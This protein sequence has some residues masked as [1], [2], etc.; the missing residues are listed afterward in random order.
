M[1][2][3]LFVYG[4]LMAGIKTKV[5]REFHQN[6]TFLGEGYLKGKMYDLGH[7]PGVVYDETSEQK[8]FGHVF[9]LKEPEKMLKKLDEYEDVGQRFGQFEEYVREQC[10]VNMK[11]EM[12]TCW[13][14]LYKLPIDHLPLIE[15]GN[16]LEN[17][18]HN[19]SHQQ[20]LKSV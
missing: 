1:I 15:S 19:N 9:A 6:S 11:G 10:P 2:S 18:H 5:N 20:F 12:I 7:Y 8:V 3:K 16:Y 13:V 4:T 14:Y 17:L